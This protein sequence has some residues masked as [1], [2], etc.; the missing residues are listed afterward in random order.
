MINSIKILV[1]F[2]FTSISTLAQNLEKV[3]SIVKLYPRT[4]SNT[5]RLSQRILKDF[6]TEHDK[7]RAIFTWIAFNISYD[8]EFYQ[9]LTEN[10]SFTY[11]GNTDEEINN[12]IIKEVLF[13]RKAVC[14]GYSK[15]FD[16]LAKEV[17]LETQIV[18][19]IAK[20]QE[21]EIGVQNLPVNHAWNSVK[22]DGEWCLMDVT[23]GSGFVTDNFQKF[24]RDFNPFYFNTPPKLF[25]LNHHPETGKWQNEVLNK[26]T[27]INLPIYH[28]SKNNGLNYEIL[29][30]KSGVILVKKKSKIIFKI[31]NLSE[32]TFIS[33][34]TNDNEESIEVETKN[35]KGDTTDFEISVDDNFGE[36]L[37]LNIGV[38]AYATFKIVIEN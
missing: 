32:E 4:Y 26:Q 14:D 38:S 7:A 34:S 31:L 6:S 10:S 3:D 25:F 11:N 18:I 22:I 21:S 17:G 27:F 30:P 1:L 13:K 12:Q 9:K 37:T 33:F 23:W 2:L 16:K 24:K 20:I 8:V 5:F 36:Y 19:G 28:I 15:L 29:E 35:K